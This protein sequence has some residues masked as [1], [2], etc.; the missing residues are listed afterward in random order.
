MAHSVDDVL[1]LIENAR[2]IHTASTCGH[3]CL[4]VH[5]D[6]YNGCYRVSGSKVWGPSPEGIVVP[7]EW[8]QWETPFMGGKSFWNHWR[9]LHPCAKLIL[10]LWFSRCVSGC[11]SRCVSRWVTCILFDHGDTLWK[12]AQ[13][14]DNGSG[15]VCSKVFQ[16]LFRLARFYEMSDSWTS[17]LH[18]Y[19]ATKCSKYCSDGFDFT[20]YHI[21]E[22]LWFRISSQ[23]V[24]KLIRY[25][26][27]P[28]IAN[29]LNTFSPELAPNW[30]KSGPDIIYM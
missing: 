14:R 27:I 23:L 9:R 12:P 20:K 13:R 28:R 30:S 8:N 29:F 16:N 21:S 26:S 17:L 2:R 10:P 1:D 7:L 22:H 5:Y 25:S 4:V 24:Q 15:L 19:F 6:C 3:W 11:V 18:Y